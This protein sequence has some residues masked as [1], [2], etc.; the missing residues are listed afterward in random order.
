VARKKND[1]EKNKREGKRGRKQNNKHHTLQRH[2]IIITTL[3][4]MPALNPE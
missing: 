1:I 2:K 3:T 4:T